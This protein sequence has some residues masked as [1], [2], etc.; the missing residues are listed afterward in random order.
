MSQAKANAPSAEGTAAKEPPPKGPVGVSF[1]P[2]PVPIANT[3]PPP[4]TIEPL[5]YLKSHQL[6]YQEPILQGEK[7]T[8]PKSSQYLRTKLVLRV[9]LLGP[10][11]R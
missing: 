4:H 8:L 7:V 10:L 9:S 11:L 5:A 1:V 6:R 2:L 3:L